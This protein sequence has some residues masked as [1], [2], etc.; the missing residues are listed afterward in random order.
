MTLPW[1]AMK[2]CKHYGYYSYWD[3]FCFPT[4]CHG[5]GHGFAQVLSWIIVLRLPRGIKQFIEWNIVV[6]ATTS[7]NNQQFRYQI[8]KFPF[9]P[10]M[11]SNFGYTSNRNVIKIVLLSMFVHTVNTWDLIKPA[12][13]IIF[14]VIT[15]KKHERRLRKYGNHIHI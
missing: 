3:H 13:W 4:I 15:F 9:Y 7:K 5:V 8:N 14:I 11:S 12:S 1:T 10:I 2:Y 6:T